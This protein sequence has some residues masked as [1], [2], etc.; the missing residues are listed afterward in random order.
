MAELLFFADDLLT[1]R[2]GR[3]L[4]LGA[5]LLVPRGQV[6][7][8]PPGHGNSSECSQSPDFRVQALPGRGLACAEATRHGAGAIPNR[9]TRLY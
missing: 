9:T 4:F 1:K 7:V 2:K 3:I 6:I 5:C 8:L